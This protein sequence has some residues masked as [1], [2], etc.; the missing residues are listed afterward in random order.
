MT[1]TS[2]QLEEIFHSLVRRLAFGPD[3]PNVTS[4]AGGIATSVAGVA[5]SITSV[6]AS[7][8]SSAVDAIESAISGALPVNLTLGSRSACLTY[9]KGPP[10]CELPAD[11]SRLFTGP[12]SHFTDTTQIQQLMTAL[13]ATEYISIQAYLVAGA[14]IALITI[15]MTGIFLTCMWSATVR[16]FFDKFWTYCHL[17]KLWALCHLDKLWAYCHLDKF[18]ARHQLTSFWVVFSVYTIGTIVCVVLA[19][20]SYG[21]VLNVLELLHSLPVEEGP[22]VGLLRSAAIATCFAGLFS[23]GF[24]VLARRERESNPAERGGSTESIAEE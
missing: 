15:M 19:W 22:L 17:D 4:E 13:Q 12:L 10:Q 8:T 5:P 23:L 21:V 14:V 18:W 16:C 9:Q 2:S 1:D 3:I 6:V 11:V 7:I 20:S 24:M